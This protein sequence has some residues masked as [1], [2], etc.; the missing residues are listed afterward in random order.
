MML[1]TE[2]ALRPYSGPKLLVTTTYWPTKFV[3]VGKVVVAAGGDSRN[4]QRQAIQS[5][6]LLNTGKG[7]QSEPGVGVG[8][9]RL[10]R[11]YQGGGRSHFQRAASFTDA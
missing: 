9:L 3:L 7:L 8:N 10:G 11:V 5:L 6:I 4:K 2:P 1:T